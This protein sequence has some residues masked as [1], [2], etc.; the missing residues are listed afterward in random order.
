M[1]T[2]PL[3]PND[4]SPHTFIGRVVEIAYVFNDTNILVTLQDLGGTTL[5]YIAEPG[6]VPRMGEMVGVVK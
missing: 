6:N 2:N 1:T 3:E 4:T 5:S